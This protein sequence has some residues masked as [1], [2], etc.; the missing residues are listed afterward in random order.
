[1]VLGGCAKPE[2][3]RVLDGREVTGRY[4]G[5]E[6]YALY[7]RAAEAEARGDFVAAARLYGGAAGE[8]DTSA[9]IWT[10][11][12]AVRCAAR[13]AAGD[14]DAAFAKA[15]AL[16]PDYEPLHREQAR[17]AL[18]RGRT[19]DALRE[20]TRARQLDPERVETA[21]LHAEALE[22]A[23]RRD[24]AKQELEALVARHP[25]SRSAWAALAA[26]AERMG[27]HGTAARAT[28]ARRALEER[29]TSDATIA[30]VDA[31]LSAG[32]LATA[33]RRA[34][35]AHVVASEVAVRA[36]ALGRAGEARAAAELVVGADPSDASA[37]VALAVAA[38]LA[39]DD[40][41][42]GHAL[43]AMPE[44][45]TPPSPLAR[46]VYAELLAR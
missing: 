24:E 28:A 25:A 43:D 18:A 29:G 46:L 27:D 36:A 16:G 44:R 21:E 3:V 14:A 39:H 9:E 19:A 30:D 23:G 37:R 32:D 15:E 6:A 35:A 12:G 34:R 33:L 5:E 8:D 26:L 20:A 42:L 41:A 4:I 13:G 2:V 45:T 31:A 40:V 17:C 38:D 10:R 1:M 11:L 7:A 22:R